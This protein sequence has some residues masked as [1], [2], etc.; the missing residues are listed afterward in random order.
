MEM[1][2][3]AMQVYFGMYGVTM[4]ANAEFFW[5]ANS[6]LMLPYWHAQM[7]PI[8]AFFAR[9]VGICFALITL[10]RVA[11]GMSKDAFV[12]Q[13]VAFHV[14]TCVPFGQLAMSDGK[15]FT[16]WV[17]WVQV[18]M[19]VALALWGYTQMGGNGKAKK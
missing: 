17:W 18:G 14:V 19:N 3:Q 9:M 8:G 5:G 13:T 15:H 2:D 10:G 11:M 12:K 16:P 6:P 4:T 7:D 1:Y